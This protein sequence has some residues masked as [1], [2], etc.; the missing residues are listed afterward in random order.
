MATPQPDLPPCPVAVALDVS[1]I[2]ASAAFYARTLGFETVA[3]ERSGLIFEFRHLRSRR[4]P[5]VEISLRA[6]FGKRPIGSCPGTLLHIT[7]RVRNLADAARAL[8]STVR[9]VGPPPA[10]PPAT[11]VVAFA[12]PEELGAMVRTGA[13]AGGMLPKVEACIRAATNGVERTHIIGGK[14]TDALLLEVFTGTGC[15]TMIVGRKEKAA[16][17]DVDLAP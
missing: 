1:D 4:F 7:L 10:D 6:A 8:G 2:A 14:T 13:V 16:Y 9:W 15:G 12:D 17:I 5:E 3:A 11:P